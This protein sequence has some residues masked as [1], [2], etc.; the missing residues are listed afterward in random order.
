MEILL[1]KIHLIQRALKGDDTACTKIHDEYR[2]YMLHLCMERV[3]NKEVAQ[4]LVQEAFMQVFSKLGTYD[5]MIATPG[6]WIRSIVNNCCNMYER[7]KRQALES[8]D[9]FDVGSI[10]DDSGEPEFDEEPDSIVYRQI[11]KSVKKLSDGHKAVFTLRALEEM[12]HKE[13]ASELGI[14]TE[15][16]RVDYHRAI[17]YLKEQIK[18]PN[19]QIKSR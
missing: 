5:P 17:E 7:K 10:K 18:L 2:E 6:V 8:L 11:M 19:N 3:R 12:T 16:S 9:D 4:N 1:D 13:I 14:S 15:K